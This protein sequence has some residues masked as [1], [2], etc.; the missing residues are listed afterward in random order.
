MLEAT[1]LDNVRGRR[2]HATSRESAK[3]L[4]PGAPTRAMRRSAQRRPGRGALSL[5]EQTLAQDKQAIRTMRQASN[6]CAGA[7]D[8]KHG[9]G[10]PT[11][12]YTCLA[13]PSFFA[14]PPALNG[15]SEEDRVLG[16][17]SLPSKKMRS[18][19]CWAHH[20]GM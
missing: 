10:V 17:S 2:M 19:A 14:R 8:L 15:T 3:S 1:S 18:E 9:L 5:V 11:A 7:S 6:S 20:S 16:C 4:V 12:V 13:F